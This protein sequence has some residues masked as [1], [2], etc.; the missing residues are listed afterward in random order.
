M[1]DFRIAA[2]QCCPFVS[3]PLEE[4]VALIDARLAE[5][6]G[7]G[8]DLAAFPEVTLSGYVLDPAEVRARALSIDDPIVQEAVAL[9][10][11]HATHCCFGL[12]ERS[13][14]A[15]FNSYVVAGEG[16]LIGVARKVHVTER[17]AGLF[18]AG[19]EFRVFDLPFVRLGL[20]I[21]YD[22]EFPESHTCLAVRGA[23]LIV[24]PAAWAEHWER[25]RYVERCETDEHVV[26][27]RER[28]AHMMFGA[29]CRDTGTYSALVNHCGIE[30]HGPWRFVGKSMVFAPTGRTLGEARAWDEEVLCADLSAQLL[31]DY[32]SMPAYTLRARNPGAYGPLVEGA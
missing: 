31:A 26:R 12:F 18:T 11:K 9:S 13:A 24:M 20:S 17:E 4:N 23:E 28:W 6:A 19:R 21:C 29:R 30:A 27:E 32:R 5:A 2:I 22:N 7:R 10:G 1:R 25:E 3:G 15:I 14:G 16:R 8:A